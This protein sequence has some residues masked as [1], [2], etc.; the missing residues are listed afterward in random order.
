MRRDKNVTR[1]VKALKSSKGPVKK[2]IKRGRLIF[3]FGVVSFIMLALL[4]RLA[5]IQIVQGAELKKIAAQ[6]WD[7]EIKVDAKRGE[8]LDRSGEKLAIS[9]SCKRVDVYMPDVIKAQED[10][11]NI[12]IEI[13]S[14][15]AGILGQ[16]QEDILSKLN[17]TL[18]NGMPANGA[19]I[20]R[21]IDN[22]VGDKVNELSLPGIVV[23]ED[24]KRFYP[25]GNFLAQV[26]GFTNTDGQGQEGIELEYDKEL[27]GTP[28]SINMETDKYGNQLPYNISQ[29]NA[30]VNGDNLTLTIDESLQ[31]Y[32]EKAL[33]KA[34]ADN[35]AKSAVAIVMDPKTGEILAM[36]S[37]PDFNPNDPKNQSNFASVDDMMQSWNNKAVTFTYEPGS[38]FKLVTATAALS[39][40]IVDENTRF[41]CKGYL[42]VA[43]HTIYDW[44]R[45]GDGI[46]DFAEILQNSCNVGFMTLGNELG[47]DKLY[48]YID[49]FGFGK[50]TGI[51]VNYEETGY[52]V[53]LDKVGPVE[54]ANI[55]FGQG[56]VA[57]P[58][59]LTAAYAAIANGGKMMVPHLVKAIDSTDQDGN[60]TLK[61]EIQPEL[62][63]QVI[64]ENTANELLG[65]LETV[66]TVGGGHSAYIDGYRI[67]GKTGTAQKA[68]NGKYV[69]GKYV[70]TFVG[71]APVD[72]PRYVVY[73]AIDE[74]D[75]SNYYASHVVAPVAA[76]IFKDIFLIYNIP[77]NNKDESSESIVPNVLGLT[78][79]DAEN[80]LKFSGFAAEIQG[81]GTVVE[82]TSPL[83]GASAASGSKV[84]L[85]L[86]DGK[87]VSTKVVVPSIVH[88]DQEQARAQLDPLGLALNVS[89]KGFVISQ[90]PKAGTTV[91]KGSTVTV[92][93]DEVGD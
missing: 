57:T 81:T 11:E 9:S 30:P 91:N 41:D 73:V 92:Q 61:K 3:V 46:E 32:V 13:A 47:K 54:L 10:N 64:D 66:I 63:R 24:T 1:E 29:Y 56:V 4:F 62:S 31:L 82:S 68:E 65:Y 18:P 2:P 48:S 93:M 75:P 76:E 86:G 20:A 49:T 21:R 14:K 17:L 88:M 72:N 67:A 51:D 84:I 42:V 55:S 70:S 59:Q 44:S 22:S 79:K 34:M 39:E 87:N 78:Q 89:G 71:M 5:W 60:I 90:S 28:G 52:E 85:K 26:L 8:I 77:P 43:G 53:P 83:P 16:N 40:G 74:P 36:S 27:S 7:S 33:D 19:T 37:K 58:I 38:V 15:L 35:K 25:N 45:K 80:R 12:K 50:R 6:Q 69:P 23:S